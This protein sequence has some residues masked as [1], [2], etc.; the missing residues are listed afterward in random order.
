MTRLYTIGTDMN[1]AGAIYTLIALGFN[2]IYGATKF[3]NLAHGAMTAVGGYAVFY[4]AKNLDWNIYP[5]K[6][7]RRRTG[8]REFVERK[9]V[10]HIRATF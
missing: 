4:F 2:F 6:P 8:E 5:P 9:K 3:F 10:A 1:I 7:W